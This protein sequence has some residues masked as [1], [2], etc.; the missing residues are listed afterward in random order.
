[1]Y[2]DK[3]KNLYPTVALVTVL[4]AVSLAITYMLT[5]AG[6]VVAPAVIG[7]I[8]GITLLGAAV[9]DYR[10]GF[11]A[12]FTMAIFMFYFDRM[13]TINFPVGT[14]Y[15]G[16]AALTFVA[17]FLNGQNKT[18][19]SVF[20]SPITITFLI[21]TFYQVLQV[22]NPSAVSRVAWLVAMRT[23]TSIL[24][25]L[26]CFQMF[27]TL[28]DV[29]RFTTYWLVISMIVTLYGFY[30]EFIGLTD[31]EM[32]WITGNPERLKLYF[33]WGKMRKFSFLSDP[34]AY[35]L[36]TAMGGLAFMA[37]AMGPFKASFRL[38]MA[39]CAMLHFI[40]MSYSGTRTAIA[41]VAVG[42]VF[43]IILTL[44]NKNT[45]V[46]A[47]VMVFFGAIMLF[48]PFYGGTMNRIRST[49]NPSEDPSMEVRDKKRIR[50]QQY[51]LA[52]P[53]GGGL[54]T[55]G[56]N[57]VRYSS[58]HPLAQG[59]DADSG[60]LFIGLEMG[61]I[62]LVL[63]L[64]LFFLV[65]VKGIN[66]YFYINDPLLK[67]INVAYLVPLMALSVAHFTQDAM[68]TKPMNI[69]VLAAYAVILRVA[70]FEKKL[71]SVDLV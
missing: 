25:F 50:L 62:G 34:S 2:S 55:T 4:L 57:G 70:T 56:Q 1:M 3:I 5:N 19:W 15:D 12:L 43:Y 66:N 53:I 40:A 42:I 45:L 26:V 38:C 9:K 23:N 46:A 6:T 63:F 58:G 54:N 64:V 22:F 29:K 39:F 60:Y 13:M 47:V 36:F 16:L 49:F 17:I 44:R 31:F 67:T 11:Y 18:D 41:M 14:I 71:Y 51:I 61:Y 24:I 8:L 59:W 68:F 27:S 33:I 10:I 20:R 28:K 37:L 35:G 48:G 7:S 30:Q 69:V 21:I 32:N 65:I 52:H